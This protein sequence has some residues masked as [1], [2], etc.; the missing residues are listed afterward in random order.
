MKPLQALELG[1]GETYLVTHIPCVL[2]RA[3]VQECDESNS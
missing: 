3:C 1:K 2:I